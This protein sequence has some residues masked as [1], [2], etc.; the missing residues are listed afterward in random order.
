MRAMQQKQV[1]KLDGSVFDPTPPKKNNPK[2][3]NNPNQNNNNN[4]Q[5]TNKQTNKPKTK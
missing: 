1:W 5:K 3:K 4:Q 2:T